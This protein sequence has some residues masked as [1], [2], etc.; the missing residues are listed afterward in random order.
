MQLE[1]RERVQTNEANPNAVARHRL[2][3]RVDGTL[4]GSGHL[5]TAW[6][7]FLRKAFRPSFGRLEVNEKACSYN[8]TIWLNV[9]QIRSRLSQFLT[10]VIKFC[11]KTR[12]QILPIDSMCRVATHCIDHAVLRRWRLRKRRRRFAQLKPSISFKEAVAW[13]LILKRNGF[14]CR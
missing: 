8:C 3:P 6:G 7:S 2:K 11:G 10:N 12:V 1:T 4:W 5:V 13:T 9:L 14:G